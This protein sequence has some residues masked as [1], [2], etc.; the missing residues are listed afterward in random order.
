MVSSRHRSSTATSN[1]SISKDST[2][3]RIPKPPIE[4][5][6]LQEKLLLSSLAIN[7]N[8]GWNSVARQMTNWQNQTNPKVIPDKVRSDGYFNQRTCAAQFDKL[9][10]ELGADKRPKRNEPNPGNPATVIYN[11]LTKVYEKELMQKIIGEKLRWL[12][13]QDDLER[14][15]S[16]ELTEDRL[17]E[18]D[19]EMKAQPIK[20]EPAQASSPATPAA[21]TTSTS[22]T[23]S[24][25]T[26]SGTTTTSKRTNVST[27]PTSSP[28][29]APSTR[30]K[31]TRRGSSATAVAA[32]STKTPISTADKEPEKTSTRA[33]TRRESRGQTLRSTLETLINE[34]VSNYSKEFELF[35][36][37]DDPN[38]GAKYDQV[39]FQYRD[40]DSLKELLD[41]DK[42]LKD[43][44]VPMNDF[45]LIFQNT[46]FF[47]KRDHRIH[48][49]AKELA[50]K[51]EPI[52]RKALKLE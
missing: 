49:I 7:Y 20:K 18:I 48:K 8:N 13:L 32:S 38:E 35:K 52:W 34:T 42:D 9:M 1:T 40:L 3:S 28:A 43:P 45:L 12:Q 25:T 37:P 33:L 36:R 24:A 31:E 19:Q 51:L 14:L 50:D 6:T 26:S 16:D 41:K 27:I 39:I 10:N 4:E 29:S 23:T 47:Y 21:T 15:E 30:S 5:W 11:K 44:H 2:P 17:K 46:L 22:K